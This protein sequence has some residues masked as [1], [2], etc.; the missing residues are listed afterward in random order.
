M[1]TRDSKT[2]GF[3]LEGDCVSLLTAESEL[4]VQARFYG[5]D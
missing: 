5:F 3:L 4:V 2:I 1:F